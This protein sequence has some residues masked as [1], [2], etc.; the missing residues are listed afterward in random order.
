MKEINKNKRIIAWGGDATFLK[1]METSF[2]NIDYI[3]DNNRKKQNTKF[4]DYF[5]HSPSI[6][7]DESKNDTIVIIF[8]IQY[9]SIAK[10][11]EEFG[12]QWGINAFSFL[13]LNEYKDLYEL[14]CKKEDYFFLEKIIQ[15]NW[16][17]LDIGAN[18]GM[19]TKKLSELVGPNGYIYSFEPQPFAF[20]GLQ[21]HIKDYSLKNV[22]AFNVALTDIDSKSELNMLIPTKDGST[23]SGR[24]LISTGLTQDLK[25]I[26]KK[27]EFNFYENN[28]I[29]VTSKT[30]DSIIIENKVNKIDF[31]KID[32]EGYEMYV[33]NGAINSIS[34]Y[35]P[36]LQ[37]EIAFNYHTNDNFNQIYELLSPHGYKTFISKKGKLVQLEKETLIDGIIDYYF[38]ANQN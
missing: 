36:I 21:E 33:L 35:K 6:L 24:A 5:I 32:V 3:V 29:S 14:I 19:F 38:L 15:K 23:S 27:S 4:Y 26:H 17:C 8:T 11:L 31:I 2:L 22:T 28:E 34:K 30:L 12:Y 25:Q 13:Q 20:S 10:Q 7:L 16:I 18:Y 9:K 37:I 1:C